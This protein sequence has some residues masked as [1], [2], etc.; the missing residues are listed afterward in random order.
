MPDL[1]DFV[2]V[3]V[4]VGVVVVVVLVVL[5][6]V[7][8]VVAVVEVVTDIIKAVVQIKDKQHVDH[9][10]TINNL[11]QLTDQTQKVAY[12]GGWVVVGKML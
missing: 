8:I 1:P 9:R 6:I 10:E 4:G 12:D 2:V 5:V 3:V 11:D 7:V